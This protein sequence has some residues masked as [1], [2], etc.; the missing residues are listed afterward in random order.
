MIAACGITVTSC[1]SS[2][3]VQDA[4]AVPEVPEAPKLSAYAL[5]VI[6]DIREVVDEFEAALIARNTT[7]WMSAANVLARWGRFFGDELEFER[8]QSTRRIQ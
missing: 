8:F 5:E 4:P 2:G 6:S 3:A 7:R 1:I